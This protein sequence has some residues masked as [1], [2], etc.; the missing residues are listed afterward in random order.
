MCST[1]AHRVEF[2]V[3]MLQAVSKQVVGMHIQEVRMVLCVVCNSHCMECGVP[4]VV[5]LVP[6]LAIPRSSTWIAMCTRVVHGA[7]WRGA[8]TL[9]TSTH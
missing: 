9:D 2:C 8:S 6:E 7:H 3:E 5:K 1:V 4:K